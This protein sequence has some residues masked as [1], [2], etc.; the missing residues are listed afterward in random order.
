MLSQPGELALVAGE[1][2][3]LEVEDR[4]H[5]HI[6]GGLRADVVMYVHVVEFGRSLGSLMLGLDV[7]NAADIVGPEDKLSGGH[8]IWVI[9]FG[10]VAEDDVGS[11][12]AQ[13]VDE[14]QTRRRV[15]EKLGVGKTEPED[16]RSDDRG[17][18]AR[19]PLADHGQLRRWN[20]KVAFIAVGGVGH[21]HM[22][23]GL[24][25]EGQCSAAV[26]LDVVRVRAHG[27]DAEL[28]GHDAFLL[29][30]NC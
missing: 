9:A 8:V 3:A 20:D 7:G 22:V 4:G 19:F 21:H 25:V 15:V 26:A 5:V 10:P 23:A 6:L 17:R 13:Q 24:G 2:L 12:L 27:Q 29:M 30:V 11:G 14:D 16:F 18:R 1:H 28:F